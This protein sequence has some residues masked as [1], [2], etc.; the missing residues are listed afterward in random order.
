[1][2]LEI[3]L[4]TSAWVEYFK[5]SRRGG[6]VKRYV[7]DVRYT[8]LSS[9]ITVAELAKF[10]VKNP[11]K[12]LSVNDFVNFLKS[13]GEVIP[14]NEDTALL[15]GYLIANS[16]FGDLGIADYII[17]STAI[18]HNTP[19]VLTTDRRWNDVNEFRNK[20]I[21][22]RGKNKIRINTKVIVIK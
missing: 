16:T 12:Y 10:F 18:T 8:K 7:E 4:D 17:L 22:N 11:T 14:L 21:Y 2:S 5:G 3:L 6:K 9:I 1:M 20:V 19:I 13:N 15:A